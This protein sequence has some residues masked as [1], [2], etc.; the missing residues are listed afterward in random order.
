MLM[1]QELMQYASVSA[2]CIRGPLRNDASRRF[3]AVEHNVIVTSVIHL[4]P[5]SQLALS[6]AIDEPASTGLAA[7]PQ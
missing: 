3:R 4:N 6:L 1:E 7:F 5:P 2:F